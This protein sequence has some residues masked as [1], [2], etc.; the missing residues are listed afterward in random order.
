MWKFPKKQHSSSH[1]GEWRTR[2]LHEEYCESVK[3]PSQ[4]ATLEVGENMMIKRTL[5]NVRAVKEPQQRMSL[6]RKTCKSQ[7]KV[8]KVIVDYF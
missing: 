8:C 3:S 6:F 7:G 4:H 1:C 5:L 2:F